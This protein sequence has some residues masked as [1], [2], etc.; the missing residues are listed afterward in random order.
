MS[1]ERIRL[2]EEIRHTNAVLHGKR[3]VSMVSILA[4]CV[5]L[6]SATFVL[7]AIYLF[8]DNI[9]AHTVSATMT[10]CNGSPIG[11]TDDLIYDTTR[12][13]TGATFVCPGPIVPGN[14]RFAFYIL[15]TGAATWSHGPGIGGYNALY[16][17]PSL[18]IP[19]EGCHQV[20]MSD[21]T[22]STAWAINITAVKGTVSFTGNFGMVYCAEY[23]HAGDYQ[24]VFV[25][26][27]Q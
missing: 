20:R 7:A 6:I 25:S 8:G 9:P 1:F 10:G 11:T 2:Y 14:E 19:W 12:G 17:I 27:S 22:L 24:P 15:T 5:I 4:I 26:W 13:G 16:I 3:F 18:S 23:V 21:G